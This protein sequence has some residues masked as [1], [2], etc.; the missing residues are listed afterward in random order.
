[1]E[2]I[3]YVHERNARRMKKQNRR[4]LSCVNRNR[5]IVTP[6]PARENKG[7]FDLKIPTVHKTTRLLDWEII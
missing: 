1:M 4:E 7:K 3:I 5:I 2:I 6:R